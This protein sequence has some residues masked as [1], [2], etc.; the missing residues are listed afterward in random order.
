MKFRIHT[1]TRMIVGGVS[2]NARASGTIIES[3][4]R[5]DKLNP[6]FTLVEEAP[7]KQVKRFSEI[8]K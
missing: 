5:L 1:D 2:V 8:N 3:D 7:K 6:F 4:E